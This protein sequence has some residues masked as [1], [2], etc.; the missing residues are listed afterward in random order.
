M[1][2]TLPQLFVANT[3]CSRF[4]KRTV[5]A[6]I[7]YLSSL[8]SVTLLPLF[9]RLGPARLFGN[10]FWIRDS[11][12]EQG[13]RGAMAFLFGRSRQRTAMD[14]VKTTKELLGK[15][16]TQEG[17]TAKVRRHR[18]WDWVREEAKDQESGK[19]TTF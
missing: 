10:F 19:V 12:W 13:A 5:D 1:P 18:K 8:S 9:W 11:P 15:L 3:V 2:G 7:P 16:G 6:S 4:S 14:M 17:Q